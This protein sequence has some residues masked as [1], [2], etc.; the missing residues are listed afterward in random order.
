MIIIISGAG[1]PESS[2]KTFLPKIIKKSKNIGSPVEREGEWAFAVS[3]SQ[4][5]VSV[6]QRPLSPIR[7][8][9]TPSPRRECRGV[10]VPP[11]AEEATRQPAT[12]A[13][14]ELPPLAGSRVNHIRQ[15]AEQR[16]GGGGGSRGGGSTDWLLPGDN[17]C[18]PLPPTN[19]SDPWE[20]PAVA[21][22]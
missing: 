9:Q 1:V 2:G 22:L 4:V 15:G 8:Q 21:A 20:A 13:G 6:R 17:L 18:S 11:V 5:H 16:R 19:Q 3:E 14:A 12:L 7:R 10:S